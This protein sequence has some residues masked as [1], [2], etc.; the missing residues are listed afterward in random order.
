MAQS[1][2]RFGYRAKLAR[3]D[4]DLSRPFTFTC[5]PG[6]ELPIFTDFATPG[7]AYYIKHDLTYLRTAPLAAP[8]MVDIKAHFETFFVPM[9]MIYEP[10]ENS[11]FMINV[12]R[13]SLYDISKL[14]NI[15]LPLLDYSD[16]ISRVHDTTE[17]KTLIQD[18]F[19]MADLLGL[20]PF[21]FAYDENNPKLHDYA[22]N[23]FPWKLLAYHTIWNYYYRLDD[24]S[25]FDN[26]HSNWDKFYDKAS[27]D[28]VKVSDAGFFKV[29]YRPW[30]FDYYT[31]MY[32]SPI[33]SDAN[34]QQLLQS[35][36]YTDLLNQTFATKPIT[37]SG[38]DSSANRNTNAFSSFIP[39][40]H[41]GQVAQITGAISTAL[42]RQMFANEKLAMITGRTKKTYDA[43]VLAHY[44]FDVPHDVK[45][46]ISLIGRSTFDIHIGEVTSLAST[47]DAP[48]GE[49]AGKGWSNG[50]G[51]QFKFEAP[52]H[53][54]IM[55]LFCVEPEQ[56]YYGGFDKDNDVFNFQD[57]P[58]PEFD[59]L[60]NVPMFR[61]E[62]G[63]GP[64]G[65]SQSDIVGWKE[66]YFQFKRKAPRTTVAFQNAFDTD[67]PDANPY[68]SYALANRPFNQYG[69]QITTEP[70]PD[71]ES[72]FYISPNAMDQLMLV[73]YYPYWQDGGIGTTENWNAKP[74]LCYARDP[75]I[76]DSFIKCKKVS[77][78][79]KDGEP[80]YPF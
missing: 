39:E 5:A 10:F 18:S 71:L 69:P 58:I 75:F 70:R 61:N 79:S 8:A 6:M 3:T 46:D 47:D 78:M 38:T 51:E 28:P 76:V 30:K 55:T 36:G 12:M 64:S 65:S 59:R 48:L 19:R 25:Q 60:G 40:A 45:H 20:N 21:N 17:F 44:G 32:R 37:V 77:W 80:I 27:N 74:W 1:D 35:G 29:M 52:C 53:G 63:P 26:E 43:Q 66:R 54:V 72:S 57:F 33:V 68:A 67:V 31:S 11:E 42:I 41:S 50:K 34:M 7:D 62:L 22:P 15:N 14:Q 73:R 49:L 9:Q 4:H 13:S 2:A 16:L 23:F 24:K 56:R